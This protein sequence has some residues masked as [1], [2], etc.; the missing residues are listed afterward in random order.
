M[1]SAVAA[2]ESPRT[3]T[4]YVSARAGRPAADGYYIRT[5]ITATYGDP[6]RR[7]GGSNEPAW[8]RD[9]QILFPRRLPNSVVP[10]EYQADR[11]DTDHFNRDFKP[12]LARGGTEICRLDPRDGSIKK[13]TSNDP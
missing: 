5:D 9:G 1:L 11:P 12:E 3:R 4:D 2:C 13:L 6:R 8:T 7:G 10:W